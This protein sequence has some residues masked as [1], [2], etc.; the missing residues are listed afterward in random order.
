MP[1]FL[2]IAAR[3]KHRMDGFEICIEYNV[4]GQTSK[5]VWTLD[6]RTKTL[7]PRRDIG[8]ERTPAAK[9]DG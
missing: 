9:R 6:S 4:G 1:S 7:L 5:L 2:H 8:A 3:E